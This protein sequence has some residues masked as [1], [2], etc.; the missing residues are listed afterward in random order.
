MEYTDLTFR[1]SFELSQ[2]K[3]VGGLLIFFGAVYVIVFSLF[4]FRAFA[5]L[6]NL[7][8]YALRLK[9]LTS[10]SFLV[11]VVSVLTFVLRFK[12]DFVLKGSAGTVSSTF[13]S[14]DSSNTPAWSR[15]SA[16]ITVFYTMLNA[17]L[18]ALAVVYSP[19]KD[20]FVGKG[21]L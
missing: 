12:P 14:P 21:T 4:L 9:T 10:L 16:E 18:I 3:Y 8:Y 19:S 5:E 6:Y 2:I 7:S 13:Q 1:P 17:Y 20:A 11:T 15:S